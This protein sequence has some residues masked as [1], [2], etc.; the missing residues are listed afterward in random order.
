MDEYKRFLA[1]WQCI[2]T[3][4]LNGIYSYGYATSH[5]CNYKIEFA[6]DS[7]KNAF[8][9]YLATTKKEGASPLLY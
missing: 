1:I 2:H 7:E 5:D 3:M 9:P 8:V 4:N 6:C